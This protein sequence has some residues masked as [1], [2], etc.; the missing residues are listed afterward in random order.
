MPDTDNDEVQDSLEGEKL[1][2]VI[3]SFKAERVS[4]QKKPTLFIMLIFH[5]NYFVAFFLTESL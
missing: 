1:A 5:K 3:L 4:E 2:G